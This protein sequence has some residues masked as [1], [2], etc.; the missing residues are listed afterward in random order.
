MDDNSIKKWLSNTSQQLTPKRTLYN[1]PKGL[2]HFDVNGEMAERLLG[3]QVYHQ[4][5]QDSQTKGL[6]GCSTTYPDVTQTCI[7]ALPEKQPFLENHDT[8]PFGKFDHKPDITSSFDETILSAIDI[9]NCPQL[10]L[11]SGEWRLP[12]LRY[13]SNVHAIPWFENGCYVT[14]LCECYF[15]FIIILLLFGP[16][17]YLQTLLLNSELAN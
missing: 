11:T 17:C 13:E 5:A 1:G 2:Y 10:K 9:P 16:N 6:F 7:S 15:L 3:D 8:D 12:K 14:V 4:L